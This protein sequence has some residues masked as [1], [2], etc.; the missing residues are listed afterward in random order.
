MDQPRLIVM[1]HAKSDWHTGSAS[2]H[3]R[4]LNERGRQDA[5]R[6]AQ[7]LRE[8]GWLPERVLSSDSTRTRETYE[9][10][11]DTI[12]RDVP[13]VWLKQFYHAGAT[14]VR[15]ALAVLS[16]QVR[17]VLV[18]GHNPGWEETIAWL[19]GQSATMP[20]AACALLTTPVPAWD[21]AV[22]APRLWKL[23]DVLRPKEHE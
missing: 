23:V 13:V 6:M 19:S 5:P 21:A 11:A 12:G 4:P 16:M 9:L 10:M 8:L 1:R 2:D 3:E 17:T 20:T 14:A 7:W 22:A 18:L 15:Q